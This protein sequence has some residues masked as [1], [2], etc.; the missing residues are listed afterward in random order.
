MRIAILVLL[1]VSV[2]CAG[3]APPPGMNS[4][5]V[6]PPESRIL[7]D[8]NTDDVL[9][10]LPESLID[11]TR[12]EHFLKRREAK[13]AVESFVQSWI[14]PQVTMPRSTDIRTFIA[15]LQNPRLLEL[16]PS[17]Y[18]SLYLL[19]SHSSP[20][21]P[22]MQALLEEPQILI[23]LAQGLTTQSRESFAKRHSIS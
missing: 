12:D 23:K 1:I 11:E 2:V 21:H 6:P 19:L 15:M 9:E 3:T 22:L 16:K 10:R 14:G 17:F 20:N 7:S 4:Y 13:L 5:A 18:M 8:Q